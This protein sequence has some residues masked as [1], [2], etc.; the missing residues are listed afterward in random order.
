[1]RIYDSIVVFF[2]ITIFSYQTINA[3]KKI[4]QLNANGERTGVWKKYHNNK[5]IRYQGQFKD[6]K[7]VGVFKYYSIL[8]SEHPTAIKTFLKDEN[9]AKVQFFTEKGVL[10]SIGEMKGKERVGKWLYYHPNGTAIL[11][12][13]NYENGILN[14]ESKT[15]YVTGKITESSHYK[16]GKLH[17]NLKRYADNGVLLDDLNYEN[18]KLQ[19]PAKYYNIKGKLIYWGDYEN[20]EKVGKWEFFEDGKPLDSIKA[21]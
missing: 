17:G 10:K 18:D 1:M 2:L 19:G 20:D 6:G 5:R 9:I 15:F 13:E 14:G 21:N 8:S 7:E 4:N 12:E 16:N 11:A 3:Q